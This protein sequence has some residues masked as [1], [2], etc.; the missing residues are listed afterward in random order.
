MALLDGGYGREA[1][2]AVDESFLSCAAAT[3]LCR[4][5]F[6]LRRGMHRVTL[7]RCTFC[8]TA[9]WPISLKTFVASLF[10][11]CIMVR[12]RALPNHVN[13]YYNGSRVSQSQ[14]RIDL[15]VCFGK[16]GAQWCK[17]EIQ[18]FTRPSFPFIHSVS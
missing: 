13:D 14:P 16:R 11:N 3:I 18:S 10:A 2:S 12:S 1:Q 9:V 5:N 7:F 17:K 8:L 15:V 6:P 4:I